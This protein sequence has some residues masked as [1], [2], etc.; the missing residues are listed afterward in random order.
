MSARGWPGPDDNLRI[1]RLDYPESVREK[2]HARMISKGKRIAARF[3]SEGAGR[4]AEIPGKA[5]AEATYCGRPPVLT[6]KQEAEIGRRIEVGRPR[7]A[8]RSRSRGSPISRSCSARSAAGQLAVPDE[9]A[10][11]RLVRSAASSA[12]RT[13]IVAE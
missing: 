4:S 13:K 1:K 8:S 7:C 6:A 3:R 9:G 10:G 2:V 11:L 5:A 12:P